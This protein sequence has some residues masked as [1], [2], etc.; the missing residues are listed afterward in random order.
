MCSS[1]IPDEYNGARHDVCVSHGVCPQSTPSRWRP[2][3]PH[4]VARS[5]SSLPLEGSLRDVAQTGHGNTSAKRWCRHPAQR[6]AQHRHR[7]RPD[8][9]RQ[10]GACAC[11]CARAQRHHRRER[12]LLG[13]GDAGTG[14]ARA[15]RS[16]RDG[17]RSHDRLAR[18]GARAGSTVL[19]CRVYSDDGGN[20]GCVLRASSEQF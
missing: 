13:D 12:R 19:L 20:V 6:P 5:R 18:N 2:P 16:S 14:D 4:V 15:S 9:P 8:Q 1:H 11:A 17:R 3:R 7:H 10:H